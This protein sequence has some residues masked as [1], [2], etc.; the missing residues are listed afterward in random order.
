MGT[1]WIDKT[2]VIIPISSLT[3]VH[4]LN[5]LRMIQRKAIDHPAYTY[6]VLEAEI[7]RLNWKIDPINFEE[8]ETNTLLSSVVGALRDTINVHGPIDRS[9]ITSA[10]KRIIGMIKQHNARIREEK[11]RVS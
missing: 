11:K 9:K 8:I 1:V 4:L 6:L 10:A 2:G 3:D 7:R 5:I